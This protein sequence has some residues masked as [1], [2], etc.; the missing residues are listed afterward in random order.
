MNQKNIDLENNGLELLTREHYSLALNLLLET[1]LF[2]VISFSWMLALAFLTIPSKTFIYGVLIISVTVLA[3]WVSVTT[4]TRKSKKRLEIALIQYSVE[5]GGTLEK[6]YVDW[7]Y[8][9]IHPMMKILC[10]T[11]PYIWAIATI[12]LFILRTYL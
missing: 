9:K 12:A 8:E 11:E 6:I 3:L 7:Q 4:K 2:R 10:D 5:R 1:L